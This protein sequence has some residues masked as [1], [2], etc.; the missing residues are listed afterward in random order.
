[1]NANPR[2]KA[3]WRMFAATT[4]RNSWAWQIFIFGL[5]ITFFHMLY[6]PFLYFYRLNNKHRTYE[7]AMV[8]EKAHQKKLREAEEAEEAEE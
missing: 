8:K 1:M 3:M 4:Q 7:A 5:T 2:V 6:D